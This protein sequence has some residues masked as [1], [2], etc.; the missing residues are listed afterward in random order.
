MS[1]PQVVSEKSARSFP[2]VHVHMNLGQ[3]VRERED[4]GVDFPIGKAI[5]ASVKSADGASYFRMQGN[6]PCIQ[7]KLREE[8]E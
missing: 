4:T 5:I 7:S 2:A 8:Y 6:I 1:K 3:R